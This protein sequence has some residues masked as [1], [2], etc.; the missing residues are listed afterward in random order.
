MLCLLMLSRH[1]IGHS[2]EEFPVLLEQNSQTNFWDNALRVHGADRLHVNSEV[3][4]C[5][6]GN[7]TSNS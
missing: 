6:I 5:V 7:T 4:F 1:P 3:A 2:V